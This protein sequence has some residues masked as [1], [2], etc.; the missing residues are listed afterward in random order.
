MPKSSQR[1]Q[2]IAF[3]Q[4]LCIEAR[5]FVTFNILGGRGRW[6]GGCGGRGVG[7][8]VLQRRGGARTFQGAG[9]GRLGTSDRFAGAE[10]NIL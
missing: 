4:V 5:H 7:R 8:T 9:A 2:G 3:A 10:A 1:V 6:G